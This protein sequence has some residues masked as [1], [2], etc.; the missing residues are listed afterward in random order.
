MRWARQVTG[1]VTKPEDLSW[2]PAKTHM[3]KGE[4][5]QSC[6]LSSDFQTHGVVLGCPVCSHIINK[7]NILKD[8]PLK[9]KLCFFLSMVG[10]KQALP[11]KKCLD[12]SLKIFVVCKTGPII[13]VQ[14][15][16]ASLPMTTKDSLSLC[17]VYYVSPC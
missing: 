6:K 9:S 12:I 2:T 5:T 8:T 15:S 1:L 11:A 17:G 3:V 13:S 14:F 7:S 4:G 16:F 10:D